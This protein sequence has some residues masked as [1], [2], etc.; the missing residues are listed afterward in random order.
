M[1]KGAFFY[2]E[3]IK[4]TVSIFGSLFNDIYIMRYKSGDTETLNQ[5]RVPLA[6]APRSKYIARITES[7]D[8]EEDAKVAIKLPRMSFEITGFARS[9]DR[10]KSKFAFKKYE[11]E[12]GKAMKIFSPVPYD[13][14]F[15]LNIYVKAHEDAL[16]IIEQ[17]IPFF[18]D[19][20]SKQIIPFKNIPDFREDV[21]IAL[22][23]FSS[24]DDYE[25]N[26][27]NRRMILYTMSFVVSANFYKPTPEAVGLI[28]KTRVNVHGVDE[29][30]Q[31]P[32]EENNFY[33]YSLISTPIEETPDDYDFGFTEEETYR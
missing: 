4:K 28:Q 12:T 20:Y 6:W 16:Q 18:D 33:T 2:N 19:P 24:S 29:M 32:K 26:I 8:L 17:I 7:S 23:S 9:T 11:N 5:I 14:S 3:T 10:T 25:S 31:I 30:N 13:I 22:S 27:E 15:D 1:L 21:T